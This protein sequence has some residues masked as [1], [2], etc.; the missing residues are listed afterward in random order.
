[1]I[2]HSIN[3]ETKA[4]DPRQPT[5]PCRFLNRCS[6]TDFETVLE[7]FVAGLVTQH[8]ALFPSGPNK[9]GEYHRSS[10]LPHVPVTQVDFEDTIK[11]FLVLIS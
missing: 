3:P 11:V 2:L 4:H 9:L 5:Y 10:P 1:M 6:P 7:S 8:P